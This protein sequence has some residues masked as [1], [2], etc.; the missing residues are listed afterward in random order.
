MEISVPSGLLM[1]PE[2]DEAEN[3]TETEAKELL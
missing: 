1:R 3:E 2:N